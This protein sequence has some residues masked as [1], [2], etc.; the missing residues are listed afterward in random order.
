M[1]TLTGLP[2]NLFALLNV[3]LFYCWIKSKRLL[4]ESDLL[5]YFSHTYPFPLKTYRCFAKV[6]VLE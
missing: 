1:R 5:C 6:N 3:I 2:I 4:Y